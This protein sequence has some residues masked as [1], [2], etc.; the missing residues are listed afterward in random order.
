MKRHSG[1]RKGF[2]SPPE[3]R[4]R[5]ALDWAQDLLSSS[6]DRRTLPHLLT[7]LARAFAAGGAGLAAPLDGQPLVNHRVWL[8]D[9]GPAPRA[10][11]MRPEL[12]DKARNT[13]IAVPIETAE[14]ANVLLATAAPSD[15]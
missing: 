12:I 3:D 4:T 9:S 7:E 6:A 8:E 10:W 14:G 13:S 11:E 1:G 2:A 5:A 15:G